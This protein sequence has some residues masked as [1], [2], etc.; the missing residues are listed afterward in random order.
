MAQLNEQQADARADI[1]RLRGECGVESSPGAK[2][3]ELLEVA[4]VGPAL[5]SA[6]DGQSAFG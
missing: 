4:L 6:S 5:E 3:P 2:L 1:E